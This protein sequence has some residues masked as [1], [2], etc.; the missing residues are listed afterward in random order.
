MLLKQNTMPK[1]R[2]ILQELTFNEK[3]TF[4]S[5][6]AA[7]GWLRTN[8]YSYGSGSKNRVTGGDYP[9]AIREGAYDLPQKWHNF[10]D[11]DIESVDGI[12]TSNDW[13]EGEV[14]VTIYK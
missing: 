6:Y 3:G 14:K 13:R 12:M 7:Q 9:T 4:Q 8:G 10:D 11:E 2:E 1:K 5:M